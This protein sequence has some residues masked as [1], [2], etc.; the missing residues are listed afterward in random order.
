MKKITFASAA[1]FAAASL[2][3]QSGIDRES[4]VFQLA[5]VTSDFHVAGIEGFSGR[6]VTN[7][8]FSAI[9]ERH[10]TQTLGDG[11]HIE[12][13]ETNKLFRDEQGRTRL[14]RKDGTVTIVDP[15]AG[16]T[17][18]LN[19]VSRT[20]SKTMRVALLR[21]IAPGELP[22][23][24]AEANARLSAERAQYSQVLEQKKAHHDSARYRHIHRSAIVIREC[25]C[26]GG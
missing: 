3:G 2:Y 11:T 15:V 1:L 6:T 10:S 14:E 20:A 24:Q 12:T 7:R 17:A 8:P 18:E 23:L 9:E 21:G 19:P 22:K 5:G 4:G 13:S 25:F 26:P 16:F